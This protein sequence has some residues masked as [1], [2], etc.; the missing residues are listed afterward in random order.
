[1]AGLL[2]LHSLGI[3]HRDLR[4]ANLLIDALD[5]L[6]VLVADFGV[7]H[8]LSAF[9]AGVHA[10]DSDLTAS[11]VPSVL[12]GAAALGPLQVCPVPG[13]QAGSRPGARAGNILSLRCDVLRLQLE[14]D[15]A[16]PCP[17]FSYLPCSGPPLRPGL[18]PAM[19]RVESRAQWPPSSLMC[20]WWAAWHTSC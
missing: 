14:V 7:S 8:L 2:H 10:V 11:K 16:C 19:L 17:D 13:T 18:V 6:H 20:T 5:P 4:A 3:L 1:M 9:A 12:T 15:L